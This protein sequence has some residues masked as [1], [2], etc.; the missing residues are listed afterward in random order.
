MLESGLKAGDL[1][2]LGALGAL[3]DVEFDFVALFEGLVAV[4]LDGAVVHEDVCPVISAEKTVSFCVVNPLRLY[5]APY[6][7]SCGLLPY[8]CGAGLEGNAAWWPTFI[9]Y[10]DATVDGFGRMLVYDS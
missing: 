3:N 4:E 2:S 5:I 10:L 6:F 7:V 1:V 9:P 8:S